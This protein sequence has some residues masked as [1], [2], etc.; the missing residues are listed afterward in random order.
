MALWSTCYVESWKRKMNTLQYV[1]ASKE[2]E[3]DMKKNDKRPQRG[4][5]YVI[6]KQSGEHEEKVLDN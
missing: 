2:R 5:T 3:A 1:W 4:A 6:N